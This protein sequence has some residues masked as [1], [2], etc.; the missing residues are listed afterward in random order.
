M[1]REYAAPVTQTGTGLKNHFLG[2]CSS[3]F[4]L[5]NF[6]STTGRREVVF[7]KLSVIV[8]G[9]EGVAGSRLNAMGS[10]WWVN[11]R[12]A[13]G[14]SDFGIVWSPLQGRSG[15][16]VSHWSRMWD[17]RVGDVVLHYS[18]Q[19]IQAISTVTAPAQ[20]ARNPY[21]DEDVWNDEGKQLPVEI[22]TLDRPIALADIPLSI[23]MSSDSDSPFNKNGGVKQGYFFA[24]DFELAQTVLRLHG[25][26]LEG[27]DGT[28]P[29]KLGLVGDTQAAGIAAVR[30][31]Q[32]TLRRYLL[33]GRTTAP[34]SL[35]GSTFP[36]RYLRAAHIK[37]RSHCSES[38]RLDTAVAM[39]VC[40]FGCDTAFEVRDLV[41]GPD[42]LLSMEAVDPAV[43]SKLQGLHGRRIDA[44]NK[45][46]ADYFGYHASL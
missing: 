44:F 1:P 6:A 46:S 37:P 12:D 7:S 2:R 30:R 5:S 16:A 15:Q 13:R 31:E 4:K 41:V 42:G 33:G 24:V 38:E 22:T 9:E 45:L 11:Q 28:H 20:E 25:I 10:V 34:C 43:A 32:P 35:C 19:R 40:V 23:R 21:T 8:R 39:L 18:H 14:E 26:A 17:A 3:V 36:V 27:G 29:V